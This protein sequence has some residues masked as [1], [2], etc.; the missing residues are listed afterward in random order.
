MKTTKTKKIF[1]GELVGET[2]EIINAQNKNNQGMKGKIVDETKMTLI[3]NHKGIMKTLLKSGIV[4]KL[5]RSNIVI[6]GR[7]IRKRPEERIKA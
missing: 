3:I 6:N 2:L 4:F 1:P 7:D 5:P